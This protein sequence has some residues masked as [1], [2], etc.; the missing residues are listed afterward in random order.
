MGRG[1]SN[2][3]LSGVI[4]LDAGNKTAP[5]QFFDPRPQASV[6]VPRRKTNT[7]YNSSM[8]QFE[9]ETYKGFIFPSWLMHWVKTNDEERMSVSW[10]TLT[11]G[12]YGGAL[13]KANAHI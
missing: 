13:G 4:Y 1:Y 11:K 8:I 7:I 10:N 3:F 5:I 6:M 2:N 12:H 9:A